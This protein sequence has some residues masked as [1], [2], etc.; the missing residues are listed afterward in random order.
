MSYS[1]VLWTLP[2]LKELIC[3]VAATVNK[4]VC[5]KLKLNKKEEQC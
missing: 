5:L 4:A 3:G 1:L 2:K